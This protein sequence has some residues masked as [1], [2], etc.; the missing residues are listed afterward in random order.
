MLTSVRDMWGWSIGAADGHIGRVVDAYFDDRRWAVRY[1]VIDGHQWLG[2]HRVLFSPQEVSRADAAG[3]VLWTNL[4]RRAVADGPDFDLAKPVSRQHR[5]SHSY[6]LPVYAVAVGASLALAASPDSDGEDEAE[7]DPHL[8][9]VRAITGYYVHAVNGDVGHVSDFLVDDRT[10]AIRHLVVSVGTWWPV[11]KVLVPAEWIAAVR[12]A[13]GTVAVSLHA[14]SI[15]LA[16]EYDLARVTPEY[17]A[18]LRRYYGRSP[19]VSS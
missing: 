19:L 12:W 2:R 8:R 14:E 5:F 16:P 15:E 11:R 18:R 17:E 10:W 13:A 7:F 6:E 3:R 1:L 9:S 4:T